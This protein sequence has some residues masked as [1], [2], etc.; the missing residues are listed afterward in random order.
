MKFSAF[1]CLT[2]PCVVS[3]FTF[4]PAKGRVVT[5]LDV[6]SV[7]YFSTSTGNTETVAEYIA[8]ASGSSTVDIADAT[9]S[10]VKGYDCLIVGAPTWNTGADE[11]RSGTAWDDF[12]FDTLPG[13][14]MEGKKVAVFGC[15]DQEVRYKY[16]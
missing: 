7:V 11:R 6:S 2:I 14:D 4:T 1:I 13:I 8:E 10:E 3:G 5:T 12:L 9:E 16:D 15:G